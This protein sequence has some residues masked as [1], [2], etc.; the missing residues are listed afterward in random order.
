[1]Y[2]LLEWPMLSRWFVRF[3]VSLT[4]AL[5]LAAC[6]DATSPSGELAAA[7]RLWAERAP[8]SYSI[9]V[10]RSCECTQQMS[11]PTLVIVRNGNV[12]SR[13]YVANG[14]PVPA[15]FVNG[16]PSVDG[17]FEIIERA[18]RYPAHRLDVDYDATLGYPLRIA[19]DYDH[20]AVDDEV[21]YTTTELTPVMPR[22]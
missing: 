11:G 19:I 12:E 15:A 5:A 9:V 3:A 13:Q 21:T 16:F 14:E 4:A 10:F 22:G 1:M 6:S 17:L 8:P 20:P 2:S 18:L 7:R